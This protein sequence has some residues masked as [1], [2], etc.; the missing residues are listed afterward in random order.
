MFCSTSIPPSDLPLHLPH[1]KDGRRRQV[2]CCTYLCHTIV[3]Y[4]PCHCPF[5]WS[6]LWLSCQGPETTLQ[7][8]QVLSFGWHCGEDQLSIQWR[9]LSLNYPHIQPLILFASPQSMK[10]GSSW[11]P[12]LQKL[13]ERKLFTLLLVCDEAHTA[14]LHRHSFPHEFAEMHEGMLKYVQFKLVTSCSGNVCLLLLGWAVQVFTHHVGPA[15]RDLLGPN[16]LSWYC[17][18][19]CLCVGRWYWLSMTKDIVFYWKHNPTYKAILPFTSPK[20]SCRSISI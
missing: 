17:S 10:E 3:W 7:T 9:L 14:P 8:S 4:L 16:D 2:W 11:A 13:A 18:M 15:H 20:R 12:L 19:W 5:A 1:S 6:W